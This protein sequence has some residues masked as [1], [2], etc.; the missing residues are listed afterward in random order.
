MARRLGATEAQLERIERADYDELEPAWRAAFV[1]ADAV[2]PT[3][4]RL[5]DEGFGELAR[6]WTTAQIVEM[7]A[8]I[9]LFNDFNRFA[10]A[11]RIPP[12]R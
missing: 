6:H 4:G 9:T 7:T 5:S 2:T 10:E 1:Y 11:L 8:V 12:T 3:R